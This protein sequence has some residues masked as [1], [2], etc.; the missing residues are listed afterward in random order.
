MTTPPGQALDLRAFIDNRPFSPYQWLILGLC[1]LIIF[2]DGFDVGAVGF[3]APALVPAWHVHKENLGPVLSAALVGL[4]VGSLGSGRFADRYGRKA[5]LVASVG[6]FGLFSIASAFADNLEHLTLLRFL[7]GLGL[8]GAMPN[9]TALTAEYSPARKRS[10]LVALMFTGYTFGGGVGGFIAAYL[11]P[12]FGWPSVFIVGG[13]APLLLVV[14]LTSMLPESPRFMAAGGRPRRKIVAALTRIAPDARAEIEAAS[15]F[16]IPEQAAHLRGKPIKT[17]LSPPL[18]VGTLLLWI[19]FFSGLVAIFLLTSWLPTL[20]K[21]AGFSLQTSALVSALFQL[22]GTGGALLIAWMMGKIGPHLAIGLS[23]A[24]AAGFVLVMGGAIHNVPLL[25]ICVLGA[26]FFNSGA[27][28]VV[29][30]LASSFYP[31]QARATGL[32]AMQGVG[33]F[34]AILGAYI[35]GPLLGLGWSF[36]NIIQV[37]AVPL[38]AAAI[39]MGL[40]GIYYA[41]KDSGDEGAAALAEPA[42][43]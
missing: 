41:R 27:Q 9:A 34:G 22:G 21:D 43:A 16:S 38:M 25:A 31:T 11:I 32:G 36:S 24:L 15:G 40:K 14:V 5:V 18:L 12:R 29:S 2:I 20:L 17:I 10:F 6:L 8:G 1:F 37:L 39:A 13:I 19:V 7:T 30:A 4:A 42:K 23:F 3:V 35:G 33:R 26:G 28:T